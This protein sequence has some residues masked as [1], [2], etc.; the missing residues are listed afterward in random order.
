MTPDPLAQGMQ[1]VAHGML[2][3]FAIVGPIGLVGAGLLI[4]EILKEG[5]R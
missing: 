5:M 3:G 1:A 4:W 2:I